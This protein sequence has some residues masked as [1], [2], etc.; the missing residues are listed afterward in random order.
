MSTKL[1]A[2]CKPSHPCDTVAQF[3]DTPAGRIPIDWDVKQL[4]ATADPALPHSFTDGDWIESPHIRDKGIRLVQTGNIGLGEFL[5][6][7]EDRK[8]VSEDSFHSLKC[9]LLKPDDILICRLAEPV[10]R[11]CLLPEFVGDAITSVDVTIFR[12]DSTVLHRHYAVFLLNTHAFLKRCELFAGGTTRK[13]ISRL[14][15]GRL[16]IAM[17]KVTEQARIALVL[18][19]VDEAIAKT[20][21]VIAK[22][23]QVRAGLLHDLL[24]RGLDAHGQLRDPIA[25][26]EQFQDSPLGPI[27]KEWRVAP[28]GDV[29]ELVQGGRLK[30]TKEKDYRSSGFPAYSAAGQDGFVAVAEFHQ[31]GVVL[32]A[33][34]AQCGKCFLA[35]GSW[36]TLA[37]VCAILPK[38]DALLAR[39]LFLQA[40][41][42]GFWPRSGSAQPFIKP[43]DVRARLVLLPSPSEQSVLCQAADA[44]NNCI[45]M[46]ENWL[47]K[48]HQLKSGL[49]TDLLTGRVRVPEMLSPVE[50]NA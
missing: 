16:P 47:A 28:L 9:K 19:T 49:M 30:L 22:L 13:R 50:V 8:F 33:I 26:P 27:P 38:Q 6:K 2:P 21:A 43:S 44:L 48:L 40:N 36:T 12:P 11:A 34:G 18:D 41:Q 31:P 24:T 42:V 10:G 14:N 20:E 4:A 23:R 45:E 7:A 29:A 46:E 15:L 32:S 25:H 1:D 17:P 37:N 3:K 39:W 35:E 5:D